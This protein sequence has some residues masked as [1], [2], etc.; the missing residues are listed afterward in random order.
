MTTEIISNETKK[1]RKG[2]RPRL[3]NE[4]RRAF[5]VRPGFNEAEFNKLEDRAEAAGLDLPEFI[6]RLALNQKFYALPAINKTA[7]VELS[8]IGNNVNQIARAIKLDGNAIAT[9][10]T[11]TQL[12]THLN[13]IALQLSVSESSEA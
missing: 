12:Q 9:Q 3:L 2:G 1:R 10:Q 11:L 7:L 13:D 5:S 4:E 6:R 8:R